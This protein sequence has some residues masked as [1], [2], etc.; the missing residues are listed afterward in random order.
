MTYHINGGASSSQW[1]HTAPWLD[2]NMTQVWGNET[3]IYAAVVGDYR[4]TPARPAGLGEGSYEDGPQYPT[5]PIDARNIRRQAYWSY[6]A[7]GYHTYGNTNTWNF[8]SYKPEGTGDWKAALRS[9]G[10]QSL[11][12][13]ARFFTSLAWWELVPDPS[14]LADAGGDPPSAA[15]RSVDGDRL[16]VYLPGPATVSLRLERITAAGAARATWVDPRTG[17]RTSAGEFPA[18]GERAFTA[19]QGWPDALLL[20]EAKKS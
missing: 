11:T 2:F 5:R 4:L 14:V 20:V 8:G 13:L 18:K 1:F 16:L 7:G 6:L 12:V 10:A 17:D 3:G 19:P 15:M 9:P